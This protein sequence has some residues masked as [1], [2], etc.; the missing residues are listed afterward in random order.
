MF[1]LDVLHAQWIVLGFGG[2]LVLML[3]IVLVYTAGW[4]PRQKEREEAERKLDNLDAWL[5]WGRATFPWI[6][7]LTILGVAVW[8]F[9]YPI[10]K[11]IEPPNW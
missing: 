4:R 3:G 10:F 11:S 7:L 2:G 6:V 9:V 1:L 8:S 5:R